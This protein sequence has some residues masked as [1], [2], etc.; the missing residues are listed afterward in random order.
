MES[1]KAKLKTLIE[2]RTE[3]ITEFTCSSD[4]RRVSIIK[5]MQG[6]TVLYSRIE[7]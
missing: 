4:L 7:N 1:T 6:S 2:E 5:N 3:K